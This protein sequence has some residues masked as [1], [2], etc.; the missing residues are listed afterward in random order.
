MKLGES[1]DEYILDGI[2]RILFAAKHS[3]AVYVDLFFVRF[4]DGLKAIYLTGLNA[5][6]T[7]LDV[8][9][10]EAAP[11]RT[12]YLRY[13]TPLLPKKGHLQSKNKKQSIP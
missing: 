7:L 3:A 10:F 8:I 9:Q 1:L 4:D 6:H 12:P 11:P 2:L 5:S 13:I